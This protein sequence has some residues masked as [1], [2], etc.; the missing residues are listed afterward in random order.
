MKRLFLVLLFVA[1][2]GC[3]SVGHAQTVTADLAARAVT[4]YQAG[5]FEAAVRLIGEVMQLQ[6]SVPVELHRMLASAHLQQGQTAAAGVSIEHGLKAYPND[7]L[8]RYLDVETL[9]TFGRFNEALTKATRLEGDLVQLPD[10]ALDLV[11]LQQRIGQLYRMQAGEAYQAGRTR[12][13]LTAFESARTYLPD[14][15]AIHNNIAY[16]YL[17]QKAWGQARTA[18]DRGLQRHPGDLSLLQIKAQALVELEEY[19]ALEGVYASLY[20]R[21]DKPVDYGLGY[22]QVLLANSKYAEAQQVFDDLLERFPGEARLYDALIQLAGQRFDLNSK[23]KLLRLK[24]QQFPDEPEVL[25][26]IAETLETMERFDEARA[27]YD[28][29]A[30]YQDFSDDSQTAVAETFVKQDSLAVATTLYRDL[31][32]QRPDDAGLW[33]SLGHLLEQQARWPE[34][35]DAYRNLHAQAAD[36][37]SH[38]KLGEVYEAIAE[39]D[40]A[41][42][43]YAEARE[44]GSTHPIPYHRASVLMYDRGGTEVAFEL[45]QQALVLGLRGVEALQ[46]QMQGQLQGQD[47]ASME[48]DAVRSTQDELEVYDATTEATFKHLTAHFPAAQVEPLFLRQVQQYPGSGKLLYLLGTFYEAHSR[49]ADAQQQYE[50]AVRFAARLRPAHVALGK[51]HDQNGE[52]RQAIL[53]YERALALDDQSPDA[54]RA[55]IRLYRSQGSLD[56]L[57]RRWQAHYRSR[58]ENTVLQQ[59]LIEAL[60]KA[61][62][63][64]EARALIR[65]EQP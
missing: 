28:S 11:S 43:H 33:R 47:L 17:Q 26:T 36:A 49:P 1:G 65:S 39:P 14:T 52:A 2:A 25:R 32:T 45:A 58:T 5:N 18:A 24:Q 19:A 48:Q 12:E 29:L 41:L 22:G 3:P 57:I 9:L 54:Y 4:Q 10:P 35:L 20:R 40:S 61:E 13:A 27:A 30:T 31:L 63:Y 15:L 44:R 8:L 62:R 51:L 16:L 38:R 46:E 56:S 23:L 21:G 55:L 59:H 42:F 6:P 37:Y 34:A 53:A 60:H 7:V 64:E 50:A